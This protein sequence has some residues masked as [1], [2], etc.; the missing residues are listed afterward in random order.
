VI[1]GCAR[2]ERFLVLH[3]WHANALMEKLGV[4]HERIHVVGS[5]CN[6]DVFHA[7]GRG[8][9]GLAGTSPSHERGPLSLLYAGK[10]SHAKGLPQ[11]LDVFERLKSRFPG[12]TLHVAGDGAGEEA[13][14]L[15]SRMAGMAPRVVMHGQLDQQALAELMRRCAVFVLPSFYEGLPLVLVEALACG[16]RLVCTDLPGVRESI[17]PQ[18]GDVLELVAL[19]GMIG[20]DTPVRRELP[21]FVDRLTDAVMPALQKPPVGDPAVTMPEVLAP[22]TWPAVFERI[23]QVWFELAN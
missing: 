5:G 12:L 11:L 16:C 6:Q 20:P 10:Y 8:E 13:E 9:S 4:A 7:R 17:A 14:Q 22:F 18:L 2:N 15:R 1:S 23:E 3:R 19:P 21:A